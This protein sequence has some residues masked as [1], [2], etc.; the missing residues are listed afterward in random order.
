MVHGPDRATTLKCSSTVSEGNMKRSCGTHP[1]P[2]CARRNVGKRT[3][4]PPSHARLPLLRRVRP[5][6]VSSSVVFPTPLRPSN[7]RL[8][9]ASTSNETSSSTME[10][11]W[12]AVGRSAE[13]SL[14]MHCLAEIP[15]APPLVAGDLIRRAFYQHRTGDEHGNLL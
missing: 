6:N 11:P 1:N 10:S 15:L 2:A 13:R 9:P 8:P 5:I 12:R 3:M 7:A 4:S 14:S